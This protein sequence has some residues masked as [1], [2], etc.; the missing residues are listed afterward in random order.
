MLLLLLLVV[1]LLLL[2]PC[3]RWAESHKL[4]SELANLYKLQFKELIRLDDSSEYDRQ[5]NAL[6][7]SWDPTFAD[8]YQKFIHSK[9]DWLVVGQSLWLAW[10]H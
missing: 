5:Y 4:G 8:Y 10:L 3:H 9:I 1:L 6:K 2:S 7:D